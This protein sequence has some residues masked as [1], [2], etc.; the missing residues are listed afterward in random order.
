M[1]KQPDLV[2]AV[3]SVG[4]K[5]PHRALGVAITSGAKDLLFASSSPNRFGLPWC[6]ISKFSLC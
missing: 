4:A 6:I 2:A 1:K 3:C 5:Q